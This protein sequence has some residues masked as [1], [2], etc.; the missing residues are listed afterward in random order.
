MSELADAAWA[1]AAVELG[2]DVARE[3]GSPDA[4]AYA[5]TADDLEGTLDG[6]AVRVFRPLELEWAAATTVEV[7]LAR[8]LLLGASITFGREATTDTA[9]RPTIYLGIDERR[10]ESLIT[11]TR[12]GNEL[13][14]KVR[15]SGAYVELDD[16]SLRV[17]DA[18]VHEARGSVTRLVGA[19][20]D[21]ARLAERA[22]GELGLVGVESALLG[23]LRRAATRLRID[24]DELRLR[25]SGT[26][27]GAALEVGL[28]ARE[29]YWIAA[30]VSLRAPPR[31]VPPTRWLRP[32][33]DVERAFPL[34]LFVSRANRTGDRPFD[35][36]FVVERRP[37]DPFDRLSE[38]ARADLVALSQLGEVVATT[39][40]VRVRARCEE[41]VVD[42][43]LTRLLAVEAGL[44][45]R[46]PESPYR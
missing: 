38:D 43:L 37:G 33:S 2:L 44:A 22:R 7:A 26:I 15:A 27:A 14:E 11:G 42:E 20:M 29:A 10:I 18:A 30:R 39:D 9:G 6:R 40:A 17:R 1:E 8:P 21:L 3:R 4:R 34:R 41:G 5:T 31:G 16:R 36:A 23:E 46:G 24:V 13:L 19:A 12:A 32:R 25:A 45:P 28:E 35:D